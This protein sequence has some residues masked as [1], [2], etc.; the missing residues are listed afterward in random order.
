MVVVGAVAARWLKN[1]T[2]PRAKQ[3]WESS[4]DGINLNRSVERETA[5]L[6]YVLSTH[7]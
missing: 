1:E 5:K 3:Y 4:L 7:R 6:S 2:R